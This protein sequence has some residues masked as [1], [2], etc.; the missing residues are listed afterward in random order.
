MMIICFLL[1]VAFHVLSVYRE[2][3][4]VLQVSGIEQAGGQVMVAVYNSRETYMDTDRM[5]HEQVIPVSAVGTLN[6][7]L[8]IPSG[9]YAVT[10]FHDVNGDHK[11]NTNVFGIPREPYGFSNDARGTFG[12]P[13]YGEALAE[14][15]YDQPLR[16]TLR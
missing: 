11:L 6:I 12:P 9:K 1:E 2:P 4:V 16:I 3:V 7:E 8:K 5:F 14:A 10:I 15:V 13:S